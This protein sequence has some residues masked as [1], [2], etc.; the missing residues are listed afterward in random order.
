MLQ[1]NLLPWREKRQ[2]KRQRYWLLCGALAL[3]F[4][5]LLLSSL[6]FYL[7]RVQLKYGAERDRWQ[8]H[9]HA[10]AVETERRK[11]AMEKRQQLEQRIE[12]QHQWALRSGRYLQLLQQLAWRVPA[13][14]WLTGLEEHEKGLLFTGQSE[15]YAAIVTLTHSL[16]RY[17]DLMNVSLSEVHQQPDRTLRFMVNANWLN[18]DENSENRRIERNSSSAGAAGMAVGPSIIRQP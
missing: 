1:V 12:Q 15:E 2:Q 14:A 4:S 16:S 10:L 13:K 18:K 5:L 8:R 7:H 3:L 11:L 17:V 6:G 9:A